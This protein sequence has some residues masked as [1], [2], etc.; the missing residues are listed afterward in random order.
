MG[1]SEQPLVSIGMPVYNGEAFVETALR[2]LL[3]QDY[4][5][6][7]IVISDNAST[8]GTEAICRRL[9]A[10][11][12]RLRYERNATN[13]G[14]MPNFMRVLQQA[15]GPYFMWAAHDDLWNPRFV[16][17]LV[18]AL[19]A[20]PEAVL[21]TSQVRHVRPDRTPSHHAPD[22]PAPGGTPLE[23]L[24]ILF[25]D[26]AASWIYGLY[27]T[28]WLQAHMG[29]W[30][31]QQYPTW[32]GDMMWLAQLVLQHAVVGSE[33]ALL[34]KRQLRNSY[35]PKN[36]R[37]RRRCAL[38]LLSQLTKICQRYTQPGWE[39]R[40]A[41]WSSWYYTYQRYVRRRNPL[42][43]AWQLAGLAGTALRV[44]AE[45]RRAAPDASTTAQNP[46]KPPHAQA[47]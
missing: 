13:I 9:V 32:D 24:R 41:L 37:E 2:A 44:W 22:R 14:A 18:A 45:Q 29:V 20:H 30:I 10:E 40:R 7:E 39:R 19:R 25:A 42:K 33:E 17:L 35:A 1:V 16:S 4:P 27:P 34:T 12:P 8:D 5:R 47:A 38:T 26:S 46:P 23:N 11:D 36:E 6:L 43:T 3:A 21:A 31:T 28:S 15:N